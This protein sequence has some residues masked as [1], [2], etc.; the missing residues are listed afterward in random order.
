MATSAPVS[1]LPV[2]VRTGFHVPSRLLHAAVDAAYVA[3]LVGLAPWAVLR[4]CFDA[5]ARARWL[6]Y[7]RDVGARFGR[8]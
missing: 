6:A 8:R 4:I 5:K 7:L 2:A 3:L 1:T